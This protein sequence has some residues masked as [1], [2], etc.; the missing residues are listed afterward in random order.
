M[1]LRELRKT[2]NDLMLTLKEDNISKEVKKTYTYINQELAKD[3]NSNVS[4]VFSGTA[5]Q[6]QV[7][8]QLNK[9]AKKELINSKVKGKSIFDRISN[10]GN[11][12][13]KDIKKIGLKS[14]FSIK[15]RFKREYTKTKRIVRTDSHRILERT[16]N[17][18]NT[19]ANKAGYKTQG[20]WICM[21][22]N[23][24]DAHIRMH[25][26]ISSDDGY[27]E[28]D[29]NKTKYPGGFGIAELDINCQCKIKYER[30][31]KVG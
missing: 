12:L 10:N 14:E 23:S 19:L 21:F 18:C 11:K 30:V 26:Q 22:K 20:R 27:F 1:K 6:I 8:I 15:K 25:N 9:K 3:L 28:I 2:L 29:G 16:K 31:K 5:K 24:R 7:D 13:I 17:T 4:A